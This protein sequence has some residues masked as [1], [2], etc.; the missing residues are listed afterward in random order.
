MQLRLLADEKDYCVM[1]NE[2]NPNGTINLV[3]NFCHTRTCLNERENEQQGTILSGDVIIVLRQKHPSF[4][5]SQPY[6]FHKV[7]KAS[8]K[9]VSKYPFKTEENIGKSLVLTS[10]SPYSRIYSPYHDDKSIFALYHFHTGFLQSDP[11]TGQCEIT[12]ILYHNF[13]IREAHLPFISKDLELVIV[14]ENVQT[15]VMQPSKDLDPH[16][17]TQ[18]PVDS[19]SNVSTEAKQCDTLVSASYESVSQKKL[20]NTNVFLSVL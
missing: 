14:C 12:K 10:W 9:S 18:T 13:D 3:A 1:M 4:C 5:S 15:T 7:Q 17:S 16:T 6:G 20:F 19:D 8:E 11:T 2:E